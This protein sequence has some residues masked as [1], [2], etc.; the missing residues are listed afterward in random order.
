MR[1]ISFALDLYSDS[2]YDHWAIRAATL[3]A[4]YR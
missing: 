2:W 3:I 4:R 1:L